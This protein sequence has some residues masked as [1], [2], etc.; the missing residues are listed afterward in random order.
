MGLDCDG[1]SD[2]NA[3]LGSMSMREAAALAVKMSR[4]TTIS[5]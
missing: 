2:K 5:E 1:G 3:E 4:K